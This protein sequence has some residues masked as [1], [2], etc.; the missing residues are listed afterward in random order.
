MHCKALGVAFDF[1][2]SE[3]RILSVANT[4]ARKLELVQQLEEALTL[5]KLDKQLCLVLRGKLGFA[6][7]FLH[8]RLGKLVLKKLIDHAYGRTS[9]ISDDLR[10]A[11]QAMVMRLK[12]AK[13][14]EISANS[15]S[16]WFLYTDASFEPE[17]ATGGLGGV[18]IDA[19][20]KVK[21]WF[22][23]ILNED[24]C[25]LLGAGE[26]RTI[27][28]ELEL[29][30]SILALS[31]WHGD[32]GDEL[33][34]H[35]GDNGGVRF[36]LIKAAACGEVGQRLMEYHLRLEALSGSRTWFARVPTE[37]SISD[38]PSRAVPHPLL[39]HEADVSLQAEICLD[40]I[41]SYLKQM[42][43]AQ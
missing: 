25:R 24:T 23:L 38:Y 39:V 6:D 4:E 11:L 34:V 36:S 7:S 43:M 5:G 17:P 31:L 13:P 9:I 37:A 27:I 40:A 42:R 41:L 3:L 16:Q 2:R 1:S 14:K 30:A 20:G 35:F 12:Q 29:F 15:F 19:F 26:K 10:Q 18:L 8:G 33:N 21:Y 32:K 22:G 28:Y